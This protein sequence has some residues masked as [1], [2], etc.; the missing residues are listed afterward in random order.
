M[1]L[2][3]DALYRDF[4]LWLQ[5]ITGYSDLTDQVDMS[6]AKYEHTG[7]RNSS[8]NKNMWF[9]NLISLN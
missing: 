3:R 7:T 9:A 6:C 2:I 4:R 8:T 5:E 1:S